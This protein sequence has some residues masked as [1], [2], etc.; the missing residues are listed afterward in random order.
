MDSIDSET[1]RPV[2]RST[3]QASVKVLRY[4]PLPRGPL[5]R[6]RKSAV[7]KYPL[8]KV[9]GAKDGDGETDSEDGESPKKKTKESDEES[10]DDQTEEKMDVE[11][12]N[13]DME[14][15]KKQEKDILQKTCVKTHP[16]KPPTGPHGD[17]NFSPRV[18]IHERCPTSLTVNVDPDWLKKNKEKKTP[19]KHEPPPEPATQIRSQTK[20]YDPLTTQ[21]RS[22]TDYRRTMELKARSTDLPKP[23][24]LV[25]SQPRSSQKFDPPR[26]RKKNPTEKLQ[27]SN[28]E[29]GV[30]LCVC[31]LVLVLLLGCAALQLQGILPSLKATAGAPEP[32]NIGEFA[33]HLSRL[34]AAFPSQLS[35]VWKRIR[36][37]LEKHLR[38]EKPTEPVSLILTA[39][40]TSERTL[41][42]LARDLSSSYAAVI[43]ASVLHIDGAGVAG[44]DSDKV[45][46]DIDNQLRS[47]FD[48]D[49]PVAV[50]HRFEELP[51]DSTI[52]FYRYCDHESAAYKQVFLLFTVLL[53]DDKLRAD[54]SMKEVEEMVQDYV[55][56]RLV[57]SEFQATYNKMDFD[58]FGGLWSRISHLILPVLFEDAVEKKGC[59]VNESR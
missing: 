43:N 13:E 44:Q 26:Q 7:N 9:N 57:D 53:P 42:C 20:N 12:S 31:G 17:M 50:I 40:K 4:E 58:K 24:P 36:I 48:G 23:Y 59:R 47:A 19:Q 54:L 37:H 33:H 11:E 49:K 18:E 27:P 28:Q 6:T 45:K 30:T 8:R 56:E 2:R 35:E 51:P 16:Q 22:M 29:H 3:R 52:I 55:K 21:R 25:I 1:K 46:L 41:S 32:V 14:D 38:T 34:K 5:K 39:G 10:A 15:Q